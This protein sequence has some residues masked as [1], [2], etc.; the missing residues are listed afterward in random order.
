MLIDS[1][2]LAEAFPARFEEARTENDQLGMEGKQAG[3]R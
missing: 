2:L 3:P 1:S